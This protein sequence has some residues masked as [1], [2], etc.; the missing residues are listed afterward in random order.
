MQFTL[1]QVTAKIMR[2]FN[3]TYNNNGET[4]HN[5][6]LDG[7]WTL[8]TGFDAPRYRALSINGMPF[9]QL[10]GAAQV[11]SS[12]SSNTPLNSS[13]PLPSAYCPENNH[14]Y[15][16]GDELSVARSVMQVAP[17]GVVT[18][19]ASPTFP[20]VIAEIDGIIPLD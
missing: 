10:S 18:A 4:W 11:S 7:G 20:F 9:L 8:V 17:T 13:N 3:T 14:R 15:R 5:I 6:T 16:D 19:L 2:L 12:T 1:A